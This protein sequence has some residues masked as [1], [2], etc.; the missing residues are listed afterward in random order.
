[1]IFNLLSNLKLKSGVP[2]IEE[3]R[4]LGISYALG[5]DNPS[6]SDSQNMFQAMKLTATL[7][8]ITHPDPLPE[9]AYNVFEA[10]TRGGAQAMGQADSIGELAV[11]YRADCYLVDLSD[12]S[13]LPLNSAVRQLVYSES[14]RGVTTVVVDGDVVIKD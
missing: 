1:V 3:V 2:P 8:S 5:C 9:L 13:W 7:N 14:G 12:P 11:G 6:C 10:A 4:R